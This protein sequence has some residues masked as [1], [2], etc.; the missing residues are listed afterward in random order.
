T[1]GYELTLERRDGSWVAPQHGDYPIP[2]DKVNL[3]VSQLAGLRAWEPKTQD[4]ELYTRIGVEDVAP[5]ASS[6]RVVV[7]AD[8]D[9]PV[10]DVLVGRS[11]ASIGARPSGG[12]FV[13]QPDEAQSWL[14]AGRVTI[15][16]S[17]GEWLGTV[18]HVRAPDI[19][20]IDVLAGERLLATAEKP[21]GEPNY[22]LSFLDPGI[23]ASGATAKDE[24]FK[25]M[26][27]VVVTTTA[28]EV[29][30][31]ENLT[32][33]PDARRVVFETEAGMRIEAR[34]GTLD[35]EDWVAFAVSA[36]G[37][38]EGQAAAE[39]MAARVNGRAFQLDDSRM[40]ALMTP[41]GDLVQLPTLQ[42]EA[43]AQ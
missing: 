36:T 28:L 37:G 16:Q 21:T 14:A 41:M 2:D 6:S 17:I 24:G 33:A 27:R 22:Q 40:S 12:L 43:S 15:P 10:A 1:N 23:L 9:E 18:V 32:F 3:L 5:E 34:V 35:G 26:T 8:G 31:A 11:A 30:A 13:R 20:K 4:P 29:T 42:P 25:S 19:R 39:E 7:S 38:G